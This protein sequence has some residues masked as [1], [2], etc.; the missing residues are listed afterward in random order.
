MPEDKAT[1]VY[2][3]LAHV[4]DRWLTGDEAAEPCLGFYEGFI[5]GVPGRILE[6]GVGTGRV[7]LALMAAGADV[8]GLDGSM[9]MLGSSR[10]KI[11]GDEPG[12]LDLVCGMFEHLPFRSGSFTMA[13]LPMRTLGHL[14]D[15]TSITAAF[16]EVWRVLRHG[17]RFVFDHYN[18]DRCWAEKHDGRPRLMYAGPLDQE[19][20]L[21]ILIWDRYDYEFELERL[22]CTVRVDEVSPDLTRVASSVSFSFR[23]FK[24]E[25]VAVLAGRVGFEVE[26]CW[27]DFARGPFTPDSD[28]MIFVLRKP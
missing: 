14:T 20:G 9:A 15:P 6:L 19:R 11:M 3:S 8:V 7:S 12:R 22:R 13:V 23:W 4:Y 16:E 18:F 2:D 10:A 24:P 21:A 17:G 25:E 5:K 28:Q 26:S 27:G 1:R